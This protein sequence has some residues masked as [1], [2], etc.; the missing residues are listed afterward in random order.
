MKTIKLILFLIVMT[1]LALALPFLKIELKNGLHGLR[2]E[3]GWWGWGAGMLAIVAATAFLL[4]IRVKQVQS[5]RSK[6][7]TKSVERQ[8]PKF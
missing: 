2:A 6:R 1:F 3:Y 8:S 5:A 4:W 7:A